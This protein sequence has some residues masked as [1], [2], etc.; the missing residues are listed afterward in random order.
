M[1][2]NGQDTCHVG[3]GFLFCHYWLGYNPEFNYYV[4]IKPNMAVQ[5][6]NQS[7]TISTSKDSLI[8]QFRKFIYEPS[9]VTDPI[10]PPEKKLKILHVA[11]EAAPFSSVG[12]LSSVVSYLSKTLAKRG[13]DVRIFMPKFGT[14][15]EKKYELE[16]VH[17]GLRVAAG[18]GKDDP[19]PP[20]L[21]C[22]VKKYV[23]E[24][25]V[26]VYFLE[27]MEF[28]EKRSNVYAYSD[29]HIRWALLSYGALK[30]ICD[31]V[32]WTP[33]VVHSHDWHTSLVPN[34]IS[35]KYKSNSCLSHVATVLTVHNMQFQGQAV[36]PTS[37]L[38]FDD[39]KSQIPRLFSE[40]LKRLNYL[41]RGIIYSDLVNTVSEGYARQILTAEYGCGLDKLLLE[42]RSKLFGVVNGI[43][44]EKFDP[45]SDPLLEAKFDINSLS[46]RS[47]NKIKL[48]KEFGLEEDPA[49]PVFGFV[50]RLDH[51]KGVDLMLEVLEK[52]LKDFDAQFVLVGSGD[53]NYEKHAQKLAKMFP[54]KVGV[55]TY[56]NFT[57]P[58][59]V[60]GG[61]DVI[62][63]P[64]RFEP[65]GIVQMEAMRYGAIPVVRATGGLD[66][67]VTDFN[68][69]THEGNGFK[70]KDFDGWSLYGQMV[71]A[72]ETYRNQDVWREIQKNAMNADFSWDRIAVE[73]EDLY[74]KAMLFKSE[75]YFHG[76]MVE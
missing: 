66:D 69:A 55:H 51:Q 2:V 12:G 23:T 5:I 70:F 38:N 37:E 71:R 56:P 34:I 30:Y 57:L 17:K 18:Y 72:S 10:Y 60:F 32:D 3:G 21:I 49:I 6:V 64:S 28:Y 29:D 8:G 62:L 42:L 36:D 68:P 40:R 76:G 53:E 35:T 19:H 45:T 46:E 4:R 52:F 7:P 20:Y 75:G 16:L 59:I 25:G 50:G 24:E 73:Y 14:I 13:H 65:C 54:S 1:Q 58:K 63:M 26:I 9:N 48:Q 39:G 74:N 61:A 43:D 22:N 27:N 47:K 41:R 31:V 33:D 11:A 44:Y 15:N 67:T